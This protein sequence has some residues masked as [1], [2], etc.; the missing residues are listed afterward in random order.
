MAMEKPLTPHSS[1]ASKLGELIV[2]PSAAQHLTKS[3][4]HNHDRMPN[5]TRFRQGEHRYALVKQLQRFI[6]RIAFSGI[7]QIEVKQ[8]ISSE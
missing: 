7:P 8:L 4:D 1:S 3:V 2:P 5:G 6:P